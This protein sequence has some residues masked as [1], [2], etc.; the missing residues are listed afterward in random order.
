MRKMV[1]F[2]IILA[3]AAFVATAWIFFSV[4]PK[5]E[6][7]HQLRQQLAV[8]QEQNQQLENSPKPVQHDLK[9][10]RVYLRQGVALLHQK[11]YEQAIEQYD[12]ALEIFPDD[13]YGWSLKGYA[14]FR[15]DRIPE[16]IEANRKAVQLDPGDPLNFIDLAKSYCAAKQYKDAERVLLEDPTPDVASEIQQYLQTDGEIRR[17]CKPILARV[18][19][20]LLPPNP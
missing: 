16:S 8:A 4:R 15:A 13:P 1:V 6:E 11:Q 2:Q 12:K 20:G 3:T 9:Q 5:V 7:T 18:S 14:L 10:S 17:V 19:K